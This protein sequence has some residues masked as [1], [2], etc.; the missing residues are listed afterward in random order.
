MEDV[1]AE[2]VQADTTWQQPYVEHR[3]LAGFLRGEDIQKVQPA[4]AY[5]P[6]AISAQVH[7][8]LGAAQKLPA[9]PHAGQ[10]RLYPVEEP[11]AL[12]VLQMAS[13]MLP[14][15]ADMPVSYSWVEI[16]NLIATASVSGHIPQA[17]AVSNSDPQELAQYS[18]FGPPP[19]YVAGPNGSLLF[20][21]AVMV[22][23]V[24]PTLEDDQLVIRYRLSPALQPIIVG[25][26]RGRFYLLNAYARVLQALISKVDKL[27]C[28]VHYGLDLATPGMGVKLFD[29]KNGVVNHFG[30]ALLSC[31]KP[32]M[33]TDFL[34][35]SLSAVFPAR[36]SFYMLLPSIQA[37]QFQ[38]TTPATS[39]L[40][41]EPS[42]Q[43]QSVEEA[44][45]DHYTVST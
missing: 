41:L 22:Q 29:P 25:Y 28:L 4:A 45:L 37:H 17:P 39:Q 40:P 14:I 34:D 7:G 20:S 12:G 10:C 5:W 15:G 16:S 1:M 23:P 24:S 43:Q 6:A 31:D 11:E 36:P 21:S 33:M 8:L 27:L 26:E 42:S 32:P 18:L 13:Q 19:T 38:F 44:H 35:P 9:R 2:D 30:Y 3:I